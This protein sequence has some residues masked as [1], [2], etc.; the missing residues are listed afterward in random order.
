VEEVLLILETCN[1]E[2]GADFSLQFDKSAFLNFVINSL[3]RLPIGSLLNDGICSA[4]AGP[5]D[6]TLRDRYAM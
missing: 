2:S 5:L 6:S 4:L 1:L 3:V